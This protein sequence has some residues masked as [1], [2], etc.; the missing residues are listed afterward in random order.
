[1]NKPFTSLLA[2]ALLVAGGWAVAPTAQAQ[3]SPVPSNYS[4]P[5]K[6]DY[7]QYQPQVIETVNWLEKTPVNQQPEQ[8]QAANRFLLEWMSGS[9]A[10]SVELQP[11]FMDLCPKNPDALMLFMGG[12]SRYQLQHPDEKDAVNLN[13]EGLKAVL[14]S[15]QTYHAKT[16]KKLEALQPLLANGTLP[17]WVQ[18]QL[19][20]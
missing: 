1:M 16:N 15:Y 13:V 9:P 12:W 18:K 5:T 10:V 6:A 8:R 17:Q 19:K 2:T 11:Y 14:Q 20:G 3:Q 7:A 4:F